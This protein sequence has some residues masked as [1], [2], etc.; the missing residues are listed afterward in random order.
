MESNSEVLDDLARAKALVVGDL[1]LDRYKWGSVSRI[2]P[3]APVPVVDLERT[4]EKL[5]GAGNAAQAMSAI[6][7]SISLVGRLGDDDP[8][9]VIKELLRSRDIRWNDFLTDNNH[10]TTVKTRIIAQNQHL[11]RLDQERKKPVDKDQLVNARD[12]IQEVIQEHDVVLLSDYGKGVFDTD[13]IEWWIEQIHEVDVPIVIDPFVDHV[14]FYEQADLITPNERELREG[15]A[16]R[17]PDTESLD[18]LAGRCMDEIDL[19]ALLVTLGEEGMVLYEQGE[20]PYRIGTEARDV[21]DVTGA[22]DTVAGLMAMGE[23]TDC[24]R[25]RVMAVANAAAGAVVERMG[26]AAIMA[27]QIREFLEQ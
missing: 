8:G 10:P 2:S 22:G 23:A 3:E 18:E 14:R 1:I 6:G 25:R 20:E 21:Y 26:T 17:R 27:D 24:D 12:Q 9:H 7:A 4:N 11:V 19:S 13:L 15:M 16:S 5:G